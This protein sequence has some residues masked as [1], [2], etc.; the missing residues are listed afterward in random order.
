MTYYLQKQHIFLLKILLF[1]TESLIR[2]DIRIRIGL[3]PWIRTR[4][5]EKG[6]SGSA[7]KQMQIHNTGCDTSKYGISIN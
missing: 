1:V 7:L 5:E 2:I 6:G 3:A 4:I